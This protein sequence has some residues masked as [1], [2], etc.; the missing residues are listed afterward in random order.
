MAKTK[1]EKEKRKHCLRGSLVAQQV[2]D[3][4]LSLLWHRLDPWPENFHTSGAWP[5]IKKSKNTPHK[6][7]LGVSIV[8]Q[9]VKDPT[10]VAWIIVDVQLPSPI[11]QWVTDPALLQ[12]WHRVHL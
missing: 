4:V 12:L 8:A 6:N 2:K 3:W 5:K 7:I 1:K 9:W 11:Q 10:A